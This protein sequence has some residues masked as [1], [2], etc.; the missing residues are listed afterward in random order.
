MKRKAERKAAGLLCCWFGAHSCGGAICWGKERDDTVKHKLLRLH[1]YCEKWH[2]TMNRW[3][4]WM[5]RTHIHT[6]RSSTQNATE[7]RCDASMRKIGNVEILLRPFGRW[8]NSRLLSDT[9]PA[10]T[11]YLWALKWQ[12]DFVPTWIIS[13]CCR[14]SRSCQYASP[15]L[16]VGRLKS[17][18]HRAW[19]C[20]HD[21][22]LKADYPV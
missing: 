8:V 10:V 4:P 12:M 1:H 2:F 21:E 3:K 18:L 5:P 6:P 13:K 14:C 19:L 20:F 11:L 9:K 7:P 16:P 22:I 17:L 15:E